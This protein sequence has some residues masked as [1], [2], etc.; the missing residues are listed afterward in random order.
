MWFMGFDGVK[1]MEG[2]PNRRKLL[3]R[4][5]DDPIFDGYYRFAE[6]NGV[7]LTL[8]LADPAYFWD[9]SLIHI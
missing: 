5:L 8:H 7:P 4:R 9:L 6:E 1:M 2:K 3:A